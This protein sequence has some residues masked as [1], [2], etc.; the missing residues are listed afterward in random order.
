[1]GNYPEP[2]PGPLRTQLYDDA[3]ADRGLVY[4]NDTPPSYQPPPGA[5]KVDPAQGGFMAPST[6]PAAVGTL[7]QPSATV[8]PPAQAH[9]MGNNNPFR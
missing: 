6:G 4:N 3:E 1:M 8:P 7:H 9:V 2:L 5:T